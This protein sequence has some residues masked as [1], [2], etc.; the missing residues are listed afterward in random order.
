MLAARRRTSEVTPQRT[1]GLIWRLAKTVRLEIFVKGAISFNTRWLSSQTM[2]EAACYFDFISPF[3]Y[4]QLGR[5]QDLPQDLK[6][7]LKP[8]FFCRSA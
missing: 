8:V 5:F 6:I 2:T 3:S 1:R 7:A 4:L